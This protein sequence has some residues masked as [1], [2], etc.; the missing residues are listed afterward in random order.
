LEKYKIID[1]I[2]NNSD[3]TPLVVKWNQCR[4]TVI[5]HER[6]LFVDIE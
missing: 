2:L 4:K 5:E 3:L 1:G 6:D